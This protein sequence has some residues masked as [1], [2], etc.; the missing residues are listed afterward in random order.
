MAYPLFAM[1]VFGVGQYL[2]VRDDEVRSGFPLLLLFLLAIAAVI[3]V[4]D[5]SNTEVPS[6]SLLTLARLIGITGVFALLLGLTSPHRLNHPFGALGLDIVGVMG[7]ALGIGY[8]M[9]K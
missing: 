5:P 9:M 6:P 2:P 3:T 8:L 7:L 4:F 1:L